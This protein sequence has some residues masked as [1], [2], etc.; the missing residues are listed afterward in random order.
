MKNDRDKVLKV[1]SVL[2]T[3]ITSVNVRRIGKKDQGAEKRPRYIIVE[4]GTNDERNEVKKKSSTLKDYEATKSFYFKADLTK[5]TREEYARLYELKKRIMEETPD[6]QV[7]IDYGK[8]YVDDVVV[9][10]LED[11]QNFL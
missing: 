10:Q 4:F 3:N 6:K 1:L 9:D 8:L 7:K 2:G 5:K 11:N